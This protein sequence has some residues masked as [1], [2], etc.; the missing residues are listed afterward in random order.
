MFA[1]CCF[2]LIASGLR[3]QIHKAISRTILSKETE[4]HARIHKGEPPPLE[5]PGQTL[6]QLPEVGFR[7]CPINPSF[8]WKMIKYETAPTTRQEISKH[9]CRFAIH[10]LQSLL[11]DLGDLGNLRHVF[12]E[13]LY[14]FARDGLEHSHETD[15][16]GD[17]HHTS[18]ARAGCS[19]VH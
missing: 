3:P 11:Y 10:T 7:L 13:H 19:L 8:C 16:F 6:L 1:M 17:N 2:R 15:L 4:A 12:I 5:S 18:A 9:A 14:T